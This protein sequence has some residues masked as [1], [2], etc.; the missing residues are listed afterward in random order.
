MAALLV[1]ENVKTIEAVP[2]GSIWNQPE[3]FYLNLII[4][5][6]DDKVF[7]ITL[8]SK[9]KAVLANLWKGAL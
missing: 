4:T 3:Y 1:L 5:D 6:K 7:E 9:D 2:V 8:S